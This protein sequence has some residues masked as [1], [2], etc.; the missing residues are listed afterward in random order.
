[1]MVLTK[2]KKEPYPSKR[3]I[4]GNATDYTVYEMKLKDIGIGMAIGFGL[5]FFAAQ[6]FFG[7]VVLSC[8]CA[9]VAGILAVPQYK[10][11]LIKKRSKSLLI[12]F[13]DL[14]ESL[15]TSYATGKNTLGA[16]QDAQEDI[17]NQH[18]MS[19][20]LT[21]IEIITT[22]MYNNL[23]IEDLLADFSA[24]SGLPDIKSF[25]ETFSICTR[26]GGNLN[27]IITEVRSLII[28]K[29]EI[30]MEIETELTSKKNELNIMMVVPFIITLMMNSFGYYDPGDVKNI[31]VKIVALVAFVF[32]YIF[33]KKIVDVKV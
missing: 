33:G 11:Y 17:K 31:I 16:F 2:K 24:R 12:Q 21:E 14:L 6:I 19:D 15:A 13:K 22:G 18:G 27:D 32:A 4:L 10:K 23:M 3:G 20:I 9:L 28:E 29:V 1:M 30:E 5:A 25:S 7:S 8:I 26:L